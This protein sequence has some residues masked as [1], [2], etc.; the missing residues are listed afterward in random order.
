MLNRSGDKKTDLLADPRVRAEVVATLYKL[1]PAN[2]VVAIL[3]SLLL[4]WQVVVWPGHRALSLALVVWNLVNLF[5]LGLY[6][7][8]RRSVKTKADSEAESA[9]FLRRFF[10]IALLDAVVFGLICALVYFAKPEMYAV[11]AVGCAIY[12][13]GDVFKNTVYARLTNILPFVI[14][15]PLAL[16]FLKA[17]TP[18]LLTL[19]IVL[20]ISIFAM[21]DFSRSNAQTLQLAIKQRFDISRQ[22]EELAL[23]TKNLERE[24]ERA[25]AANA[26]KSNFFTAASHDAR[27]PLQVISL[28]FQT[29][30]NTNRASEDDKKIIEKIEIN[31]GTIRSL[32]DRVLDVSRI[33]SGHVT[34]CMESLPL[35]ALFDKL[36]AQFGELAASRGLWLRF[37]PTAAW[38]TQD[39]EILERVVSNLVHNAIK[40]TEKGGVWIAFRAT[41][42]RLEIRDSGLGISKANQTVIFQEFA[43][44]NNPSRNNEAGL[45]LG[46]SIVKRLSDLTHTPLGLSSEEQKGSCFWIGLKATTDQSPVTIRQATTRSPVDAQSLQGMN[47][48]YAEDES[49]VSE[50][51]VGLLR[52]A[53]ATVQSC[54]DLNQAKSIL[55]V[56]TKIDVVLTDY[57]LGASG[58]G[59]DV[60]RAARARFHGQDAEHSDP[61]LPPA[62]LLTGDTAVKDLAAIRSLQNCTLLHKPINFEDLAL[63]LREL[64]PIVSSH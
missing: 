34:P 43:Q 28:L 42:H 16:A 45:G 1:I 24:R 55:T 25:D 5:Y 14:F 23:L 13:F 4:G 19:A 35:Q 6:L 48:L 33:D 54:A 59:L 37:V 27:Q 56:A 51:F 30:R 63:A 64:V 3:V 62:I 21:L 39:P 10:W 12:L 50:L 38:V 58:T 32:F 36:D 11:A 44:L 52:D 49:Q 8:Y 53:G 41:R 57:R 2:P 46:L 22:N 60:V 20:V 40:Y 31:L 61:S 7:K 15:G 18:I 47:I 17:G 26:A 9:A 29:F